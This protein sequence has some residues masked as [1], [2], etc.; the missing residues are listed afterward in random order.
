M[1]EPTKITADPAHPLASV[2]IGLMSFVLLCLLAVMVGTTPAGQQPLGGA[3]AILHA[4][5]TVAI[6]IP[7]LEHR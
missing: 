2:V 6:P 5:Q 7:P 3:P 1:Q 4:A